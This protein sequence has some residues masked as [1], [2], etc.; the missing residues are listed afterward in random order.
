[1][2]ALCGRR[3]S[4]AVSCII[5]AMIRPLVLASLGLALSLLGCDEP[6]KPA[7]P[8]A[9]AAP[10][11]Q[12][13]AAATPAASPAAS[14]PAPPKK[15]VV[16]TK[17]D[18]VTFSHPALEARVRQQL[19]K[20][21]G[22]I[23]RADLKNIKT[24]NLSDAQGLDELDPCLFPELTGVKGLYL[25]PGK[26]D[27]LRPIKGLLRLE[28][29]RVSATLVKDLSPLAGLVKLDRLDIGRTP[30]EDLTPLAGLTNLTELQI[31]ETEVTDLR[32]LAGLK[33]LE[34]LQMKRTRVS[35]VSPLR[36]LKSLKN[37]YLEGSRVE[38]ASPLRSI[39]GIK[40][41]EG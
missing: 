28:S 30:V 17:S 6:K 19:Q 25:P 32:P 5:A 13:P 33:K 14:A 37:V 12:A 40:I 11:A 2:S 29:L 26:I 10:A 7:A 35:D 24:M 38:D 23:K 9:S 39:P 8:A 31:D 15:E 21:E 16:C 36:E 41:H 27:D 4:F 18:P 1:M 20:P 22:P 34:M 3:F